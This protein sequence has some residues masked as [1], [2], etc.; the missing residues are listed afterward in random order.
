M[1][2]LTLLVK[3]QSFDQIVAG[4]KKEEVRQI[5]PASQLK[6]IDVSS[7]QVTIKLYD[8]IRFKNGN[9][10]DAPEVLVQ[11]LNSELEYAPD[12][13]GY[14]QLYEEDGRLLINDASMI[15]T[16]GKVIET[17]NIK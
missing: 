8:A 6:Y 16:L 5:T 7:N 2:V 9:E 3:A 10:H 14:I 12:D 15:Y 1:E 17:Q 11:V 13:E 4:E